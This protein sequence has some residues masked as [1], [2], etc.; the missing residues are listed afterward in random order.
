[1]IDLLTL[2]G[3]VIALLA[4]ALAIASL[5]VDWRGRT[6][7]GTAVGRRLRRVRDWFDRV[8]SRFPDPDEEDPDEEEDAP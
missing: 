7:G 8:A 3:L 4:F 6:I 2:V 1:M 5:P